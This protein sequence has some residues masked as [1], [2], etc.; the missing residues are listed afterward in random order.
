MDGGHSHGSRLHFVMGTD[1]LVDRTE[2]P[3][4][5]FRRY[6]VRFADVHIDH[7]HQTNGFALLAQLV[8][9]P[10]VVAAERASA[11]D[12][13]IDGIRACQVRTLGQAKTLKIRS[14]S[15]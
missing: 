5:E 11:D 6:R 13:N 7:A 9:H 12:G 3:A 1:E 14:A 4:T 10:G 15:I 2:T 8:I